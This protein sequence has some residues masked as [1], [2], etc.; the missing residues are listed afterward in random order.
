MA[1]FSEKNERYGARNTD[2][3]S[4]ISYEKKM[5]KLVRANHAIAF[6]YARHGL[7]NIFEAAGLKAGDEIILSP[8]TCK[9]VSLAILSRKLKPVYADISQDSLNLSPES[10]SK[11]I[12][13]NTRAI[14]FQHTYGNY[15]GIEAINIIAREKKI[16]LVE[17]CAQCLPF[18]LNGRAPGK[19]GQASVFS[20]NLRKPLPAGSG[21]LVTTNNEELAG[22]IRKL[23]DA[24]C[25]RGK[26]SELALRMEILI[27]KLLLRPVT[28]WPFYELNRMVSSVHSSKCLESEI[29]NHYFGYGLPSQ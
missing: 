16:L 10:V 7:I 4:L 2:L 18:C 3:D 25:Q 27:H 15:K 28:Y 29:K 6:G 26:I 9:V 17:D 24:L 12:S 23:R 21:G 11:Q 13:S 22:K 1:Y 14:I 8:L 19:W 20:N 5:A